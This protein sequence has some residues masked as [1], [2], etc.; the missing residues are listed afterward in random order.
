MG[1]FKGQGANQAL[2][3]G[4]A[5]ARALRSH[6]LR[7]DAHVSLGA[8]LSMFE[9]DMLERARRKV[10]ASRDAAE[11]LHSPEAM[12]KSNSTRAR[13]ARD[14]RQLE[15]TTTAGEGRGSV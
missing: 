3:Y 1:P 11:L 13:S 15:S 6:E 4:I 9:A 7:G 14:K 8:A 2:L 10:R 5:L 12:A